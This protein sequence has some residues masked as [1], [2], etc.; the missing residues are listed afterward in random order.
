[1]ELDPARLHLGECEHVVD[2]GEEVLLAGAHAAERLRLRI[3]HRAVDPHRHQLH[4]AADGVQRRAQLVAHGGEEVR[5]GAV[6]VLRLRAR[7]LGVDPR[8]VGRGALPL[9]LVEK[10]L[11]LAPGDHLLRHVGAVGDDPGARPA[12]LDEREVREVQE[13]FLRRGAGGAGEL[14]RD[15]AADEGLARPQHA[16]QQIHEALRHHLGE[17]GAHRLPQHLAVPHELEVRV[18]RQLEDVLRPAQHRQERGRLLEDVLQPL[19]LHPQRAQ[20][21]VALGLERAGVDL[22]GRLVAVD[23]D[24]AH[25]AALAGNGAVRKGEVRLLAG[26]VAVDAEEEILEVH[27]FAPPHP[28]E[29]GSDVAADLAPAPEHRP[30]QPRRVL[31][32]HDDAV[33][34]V[35]D[36]EELRPPAQV[37][38]DPLPQHEPGRGAQAGRPPLH[39]AQRGGGPVR[40]PRETP[41]VARRGENDLCRARGRGGRLFEIHRSG[42]EPRRE[43]PGFERDTTSPPVAPL[44]RACHARL[45]RLSPATTRPRADASSPS[46]T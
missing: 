16:V 27:R 4:V 20:Q 36:L 32:A 2:Q 6:R 11:H 25:L 39:R 34:V 3:G 28:L 37:H 33:R 22:V 31:V 44:R 30:S 46:R 14:H 24:A 19:P 15:L 35:V 38:G 26:A 29:E 9:A 18:V 41:H 12:R 40:T 1:V 13:P 45:P 17:R 7:G 21:P 42:L 10:A 5:L 23:E 43:A 8:G